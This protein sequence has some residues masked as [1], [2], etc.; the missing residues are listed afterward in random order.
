MA[1]QGEGQD[2]QTIELPGNQ[3]ALVAA[4]RAAAPPHVTPLPPPPAPPMHNNQPGC[5]V[6]DMKSTLSATVRIDFKVIGLQAT[7][8]LK[9]QT[10]AYLCPFTAR[11]LPF[12]YPFTALSLLVLDISLPE[13]IFHCLSLISH[14]LSLTFHCLSLNFH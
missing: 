5:F 11:S 2:R 10:P 9:R 7:G 12:Y 3:T 6:R 8:F 1:A 14:C 4:L 13:L